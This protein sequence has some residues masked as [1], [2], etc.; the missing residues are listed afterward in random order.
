MLYCCICCLLCRTHLTTHCLDILQTLFSLPTDI[1]TR[2]LYWYSN[3]LRKN[4]LYSPFH[5][6]M[7]SCFADHHCPSCFISRVHPK[8][9]FSCSAPPNPSHFGYSKE[10]C[11]ESKAR[12]AFLCFFSPM[13]LST[14]Q[15]VEILVRTPPLYIR[16]QRHSPSFQSKHRLGGCHCRVASIASDIDNVNWHEF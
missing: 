13:F 9:L 1:A 3:N 15:F 8:T 5:G 14:L 12:S 10:Y 11:T 2:C 7:A 4:R 16:C 6:T